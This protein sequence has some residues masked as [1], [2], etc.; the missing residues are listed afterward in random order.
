M[1]DPDKGGAGN[2]VQ[3][4]TADSEHARRRK[5]TEDTGFEKTVYYATLLSTAVSSVF[6]IAPTARHRIRFRELDKRWIVETANRLAIAGLV[7]LAISITG[8]ILLISHVVYSSA[9]AA[10]ATGAVFAAMLWFWFL[11]PLAREAR[12]DD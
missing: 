12:D 9:T 7:F 11:A 1:G 2:E 6:L 4:D 8:V 5:E 3:G 10:V